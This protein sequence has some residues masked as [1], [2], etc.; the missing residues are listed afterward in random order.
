MACRSGP[1]AESCGP[2][3]LSPAPEPCSGARSGLSPFGLPVPNLAATS[4]SRRV[5]SDPLLSFPTSLTE[6][7]G[8]L[9]SN[10]D[11]SNP[12][13][14]EQALFRE[15]LGEVHD[16]RGRKKRSRM[17]NKSRDKQRTDLYLGR[18]LK[19]RRDEAD[20]SQSPTSTTQV[21]HYHRPRDPSSPN[22]TTFPPPP[23]PPHP[24]NRDSP[25]P[26]P[27]NGSRNHQL[28]KHTIPRERTVIPWWISVS[29][30]C[31]YLPGATPPQ[32]TRGAFCSR[33]KGRRLGSKGEK[34]GGE[35]RGG[36]GDDDSD[37]EGGRRG[38]SI[39][40]KGG[41]GGGVWNGGVQK[42]PPFAS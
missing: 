25:A 4:N 10:Q 15:T 17:G 14:R 39:V 40:A 18:W 34:G 5:S 35:R 26:G 23:P 9:Q 32:P 13:K 12:V 30:A 31:S 22:A 20:Q 33:Q 21:G 11:T 8:I 42:D 3:P 36:R 2:G 29:R 7:D 19:R 41:G 24:R 6:D 37:S 38:I 28:L 16:E 1:L 27:D